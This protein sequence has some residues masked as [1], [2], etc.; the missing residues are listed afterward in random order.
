[1]ET[2]KKNI[3]VILGIS[4]PILMILF[5]AGS[6]YLPGLFT[7]PH[8][9]FL[10][11]S[12]NN[13]S[14][15]QPYYLVQNGKLVENQNHGSS[16][17]ITLYVYN[18][19]KNEAKEIS[20]ADTQTLSLDSVTQSPDGFEIVYGSNGDGFFP[21]FYGSGTG[22]NTQYI[23]GHNTSKKLNLQLNG[24]YHYNN[25]QFLGWIK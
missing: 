18:V 13:Y 17:G 9:N 7:K 14:S 8:F 20:F 4:I 21:F 1:M 15:Q 12:N 11:V 19:A 23:K 3:N 24:R 6:I 10:Y 2:A 25:F 16:T 5:V 22:Y